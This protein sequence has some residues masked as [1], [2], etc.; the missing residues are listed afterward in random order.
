VALYESLFRALNATGVRYVIVGGVAAVLHGHARLTVDVDLIVDFEPTAT[1]TFVQALVDL[2]FVPRAPVDARDF[3]SPE[4]RDTW[5]REKGMQVF[6]MVD[7]ANPMRVV[8]LF[9]THPIA[10][11]DL[12]ARA[13]VMPL[14]TT[15]VHVASVPDL[16]R[17]SGWPGDRRTCW[18]SNVS[19]PSGNGRSPG[20]MADPRDRTSPPRDPRWPVTFEDAAEAH[21]D[22]VLAATPAQRLA[23][24]EDA[25]KLASLS[26]R[27][28][29][30][31]G[32]E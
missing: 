6:S 8:D 3:A 24:L 32:A 18:I 19:R 29:R 14:E 7:R 30:R 16:S 31:A 20:L 27:A 25:L 11:E 10:F 22:A 5:H 1:R 28:G 13:D 17:S 23:W 2:G 15:E 12:W 26:S 21:L 9:V 4:L